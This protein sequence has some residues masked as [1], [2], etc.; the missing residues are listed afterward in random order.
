MTEPVISVYFAPDRTYICLFEPDAKGL[1]LAYINST[2]E[3]I[4]FFLVQSAEDLELEPGYTQLQEVLMEIAG[5]ATD[6]RVVLPL[7]SAY[8]YQF[9]A[10]PSLKKEEVAEL[11]EFEINQRF[12]NRN[13]DEFVSRVYQL[14]P[15]LDGSSMLMAI[16]VE[17]RIKD[18]I[19]TALAMLGGE[20]TD[21]TT[22]QIAAHDAFRLNYP[23]QDGCF[24]LFN[25]S[26]RYADV[27]AIRSGKT[28]YINTTPAESEEMVADA[29]GGEMRTI[30]DEYVPF[31]DGIFM[32]GSTL[33]KNALDLC[34]TR[35][36]V[37]VKR[38]NGMRMVTTTLG[39][40]ER[41]YV[42]RVA[43]NVVCCVGA[44]IPSGE[45]AAEV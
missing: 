44:A 33:T 34:A 14:E 36:E 40:R 21:F 23:E 39:E 25:V 7:S 32:F 8:L 19:T 30:L 3:P 1:S 43:H 26:E 16:L 42:A 41:A 10:P 6:I 45:Y 20:I 24:C 2:E 18:L 35:E 12:P 4:D 29:V 9:P 37:P 38:L 5:A 28:A 31:V 27:S 11:L 13:P 17:Q 22:S 15:K